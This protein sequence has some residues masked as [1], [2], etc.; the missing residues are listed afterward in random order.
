MIE[1]KNGGAQHAAWIIYF[2]HD[3]GE[4]PYI[5]HYIVVKCM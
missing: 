1:E 3:A 4:S 5:L 2:D